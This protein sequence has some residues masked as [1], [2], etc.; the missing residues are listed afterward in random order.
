VS[1][2]PSTVE[3][4]LIEWKDSHDEDEPAPFHACPHCGG[5]V[6]DDVPVDFSGCCS[7][8]CRLVI[9][10]G[11]WPSPV[12]PATHDEMQGWIDQAQA[13]EEPPDE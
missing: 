11:Y 8:V 2:K 4:L 9:E 1:E 13:E 12:G 6:R 10:E 3:R 5:L 7:E